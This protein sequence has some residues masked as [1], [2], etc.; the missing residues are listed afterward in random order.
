MSGDFFSFFSFA[1][2]LSFSF[3]LLLLF[4]SV[5][6][7]LPL[8]CSCFAVCL[9]CIPCLDSGWIDCLLS[10]LV[11]IQ[12]ICTGSL[13]FAFSVSELNLF[14]VIGHLRQPYQDI[15]VRP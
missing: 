1:L 3:Y 15:C 13:D 8:E 2:S 9:S 7:L 5:A 10:S 11:Y 14:A 12:Y 6:W 4:I